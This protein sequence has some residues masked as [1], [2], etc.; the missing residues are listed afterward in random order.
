MV[1]RV[2][3][4]RFAAGSDRAQQSIELLPVYLELSHTFLRAEQRDLL[5]RVRR[6]Y[7][8]QPLGKFVLQ[9]LDLAKAHWQLGFGQ[10]PS[11][12]FYGQARSEIEATKVFPRIPGGTR[13]LVDGVE[14]HRTHALRVVGEKDG[15]AQ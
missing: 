14:E 8:L 2:R 3:H 15:L 12:F 5:P 11:E 4:Q 7:C 9:P 10:Q 1:A 6:K 13:A